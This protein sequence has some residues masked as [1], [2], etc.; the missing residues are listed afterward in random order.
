MRN[1]INRCSSRIRLALALPVIL[2]VITP[3]LWPGISAIHKGA[4]T[5]PARGNPLTTHQ[6]GSLRLDHVL[7]TDLTR[8]GGSDISAFESGHLNVNSLADPGDGTCDVL[9]CTLREAIN[10]AN[11]NAGPDVIDFSVTGTINLTGALPGC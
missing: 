11:A 4:A 3:T 8:G 10:E 9:E 1:I 6:P 2:L 5:D 7:I